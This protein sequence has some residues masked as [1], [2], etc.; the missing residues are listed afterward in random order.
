MRRPR[1]SS[2]GWSSFASG[3]GVSGVLMLSSVVGNSMRNVEPSPRALSTWML[4]P[5]SS[6]RRRT[7]ARP[8]PVPPKRRVVVL[9]ACENLSNSRG[10]VFGSNPMPVSC[11]SKHNCTLF[12]VALGRADTAM[13]TVPVSVNLMALLIKLL[14]TW[15]KRVGS[16]RTHLGSSA[17]RLD[18]SLSPFPCAAG[19]ASAMT[20]STRRAS[21]S[22][23]DSSSM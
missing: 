14:S 7:I 11:T 6:I 22:G 2:G 3:G 20:S 18:T 17:D 1:Q 23:I 12:R 21:S 8:R 9:S 4:P 13:P 15:R 10:S 16:P 19:E 5:M